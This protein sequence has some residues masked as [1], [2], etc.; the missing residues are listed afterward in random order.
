VVGGLKVFTHGLIL[1]P[2]GVFG[3]I[4]ALRQA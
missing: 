3:H 4:L 1:S 2:K